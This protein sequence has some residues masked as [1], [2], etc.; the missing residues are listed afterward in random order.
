MIREA[1][2]LQSDEKTRHA[3]LLD[4][5]IKLYDFPAEDAKDFA[6]PDPL[7]TDHN[8]RTL[9]LV[10]GQL[11]ERMDEM[12]PIEVTES[13]AVVMRHVDSPEALK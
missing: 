6:S 13:V 11:G 1:L 7:A 12:S 8:P 4:Y 9:D 5:R 3:R 10:L 2:E